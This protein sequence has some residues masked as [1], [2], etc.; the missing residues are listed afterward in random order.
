M[1][2]GWGKGRQKKGRGVPQEQSALKVKGSPACLPTGTRSHSWELEFFY[3]GAHA[4]SQWPWLPAP[5][6]FPEATG[7]LAELPGAQK[8]ER[9]FLPL[10]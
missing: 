7:K 6:L 9:R 5:P 10:L 1:G 8:A 4:G 3:P 2:G